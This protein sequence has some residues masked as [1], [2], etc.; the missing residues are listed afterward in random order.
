MEWDAVPAPARELE[1][2][3]AS[4]VAWDGASAQAKRPPA[5]HRASSSRRT[6]TEHTSRPT[7]SLHWCC[8]HHIARPGIVRTG[9]GDRCRRRKAF[10]GLAP[11]R[12]A[13]AR[14]VLQDRLGLTAPSDPGLVDLPGRVALPGRMGSFEAEV[15]LA[16][17]VR[18]KRALSRAQSR[19]ATTL[20]VER[21]GA[22]TIVRSR[23]RSTVCR[24]SGLEHNRR[25]RVL[26]GRPSAVRH[27][28][29]LPSPRKSLLTRGKRWAATKRGTSLALRTGRSFHHAVASPDHVP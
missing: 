4:V 15:D 12:P 5:A 2:A 17:E 11:W 27:G 22:M 7:C 23:A 21:R 14:S 20:A 26:G 19:E 9:I 18:T 28:G 13:A 29:F 3:P 10:R 8:N 16:H 1:R 6:S 24:W 25:M